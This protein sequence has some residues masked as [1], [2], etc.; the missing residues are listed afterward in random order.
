[1]AINSVLH[2][3][4]TFRGDG[5]STSASIAITSPTILIQPGPYSSG[6]V[7]IPGFNHPAPKGIVNLLSTDGQAINGTLS[8]GNIIFTWPVPI[9]SGTQ[10]TVAGDFEF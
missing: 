3:Q 9:D 4:I 7:F 6:A 5:T 1:M 8:G 2:F 10:V